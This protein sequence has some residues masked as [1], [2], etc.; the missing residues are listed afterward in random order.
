MTESAPAGEALGGG[1]NHGLV[2]RLVTAVEKLAEPSSPPEKWDGRLLEVRLVVAGRTDSRSRTLNMSKKEREGPVFLNHVRQ[3][4]HD[5]LEV[6][7]DLEKEFLFSSSAGLRISYECEDTT[8]V[9][10]VATKEEKSGR[11][12]VN[13]EKDRTSLLNLWRGTD[14]GAKFLED[15]EGHLK[16]NQVLHAFVPGSGVERAEQAFAT[17][18]PYAIPSMLP[19]T[20]STIT[21]TTAHDTRTVTLT[22]AGVISGKADFSPPLVGKVGAELS[23][24]SSRSQSTFDEM[25]QMIGVTD[26]PRV[27]V[28]LEPHGH[29]EPSVP[30]VEAML[31]VFEFWKDGPVKEKRANLQKDG[32][33]AVKDACEFMAAEASGICAYLSPTW[34][35]SLPKSWEGPL[36]NGIGKVEMFREATL[37][38]RKVLKRFG[39]KYDSE[40]HLGGKI[41][42]EAWLSKTELMKN[43]SIKNEFKADVAGLVNVGLKASDTSNKKEEKKSELNI[44]FTGTVGGDALQSHD[45][46]KW[47][48]SLKMPLNW[49]VT[50]RKKQKFVWKVL[51]PEI[52]ILCKHLLKFSTVFAMKENLDAIL[53]YP[54]TAPES[55]A[56]PLDELMRGYRL[57]Q[58]YS[59]STLHLLSEETDERLKKVWRRF[60]RYVSRKWWQ[61]IWILEIKFMD[62]DHKTSVRLIDQKKLPRDLAATAKLWNVNL[63]EDDKASMESLW[64]RFMV[65]HRIRLLKNGP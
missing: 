56:I 30:F 51:H 45:I 44:R 42:T 60:H 10:E 14:F 57:Y 31:E 7:G 50:L 26:Y 47:K 17:W 27:R 37:A 48:E 3:K 16:R 62:D 11:W 53:N 34:E 24:S 21:T 4:L 15:W 23:H 5:Q 35:G 8:E 59:T 2:T 55:S 28:K 61:N 25:V 64:S 58:S 6:I 20:D 9:T 22:R 40:F 29:L 43:E 19:F 33:G 41:L 52:G 49:R 39:L 38:F 65:S 54:P 13:M 32:R 18:K 36:P 46:P 12:F 1:G 63:T